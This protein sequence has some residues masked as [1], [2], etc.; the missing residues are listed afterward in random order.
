MY[1]F[2]GRK[3][4]GIGELREAGEVNV[5]GIVKGCELVSYGGN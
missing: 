1:P 3:C 2:S 5:M 4:V